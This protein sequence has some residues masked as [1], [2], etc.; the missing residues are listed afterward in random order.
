M[1]GF[2]LMIVLLSSTCAQPASTSSAPERFEYAEGGLGGGVRVAWENGKLLY[3][4]NTP[5]LK[6]KRSYRTRTERFHPPPEAWERFWKALDAAGVWK[7]QPNYS[8]G[9]CCDDA[10]YKVELR[11]AGHS[12]KSEGYYDRPP[13]FDAFLKAVDQLIN[14]SRHKP[15][16]PQ[17]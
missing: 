7:W 9:F 3:I 11:H 6:G 8:G 2:V 12:M 10:G 1:T 5:N 16:H 17:K 13:E 14:D 15:S 4:T